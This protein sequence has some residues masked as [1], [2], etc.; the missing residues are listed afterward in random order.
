MFLTG[1]GCRRRGVA[2]FTTSMREILLSSCFLGRPHRF[3]G[4]TEPDS[5]SSSEPDGGSETLDYNSVILVDQPGTESFGNPAAHPHP[6]VVGPE[7]AEPNRVR[8]AA[9]TTHFAT[10]V[11]PILRSAAQQS[12]APPY[13]GIASR[14][15][16][17]ILGMVTTLPLRTHR[18]TP[19][20]PSPGGR[21]IWGRPRPCAPSACNRI[22][23]PSIDE[24]QM[25]TVDAADQ[26]RD[27]LEV[28]F[29]R[30]CSYDRPHCPRRPRHC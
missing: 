15:V 17:G 22:Q 23:E 1:C 2:D 8:A 18:W 21:L 11:R 7:Y 28:Q 3:L 26:L 30:D 29:F 9:T 5:S 19:T 12:R 10:S 4:A 6:N 25:V 14:A 13:G 20:I 16:D 27:H 24:I